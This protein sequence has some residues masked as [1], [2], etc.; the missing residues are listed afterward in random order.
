VAF[1]PKNFVIRVQ[2][3]ELVRDKNQTFC[4]EE[5]KR[6]EVRAARIK[7]NNKKMVPIVTCNP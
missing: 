6:N 5:L 1:V 7:Q 2:K 4:A 3:I